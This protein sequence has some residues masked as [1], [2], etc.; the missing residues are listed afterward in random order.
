MFY[1]FKNI[2]LLIL[3]HDEAE[4]G[5]YKSKVIEIYKGLSIE[6]WRKQP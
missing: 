6:R 3:L 1:D 5:L 2:F 4:K